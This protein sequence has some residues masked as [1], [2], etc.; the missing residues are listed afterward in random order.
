MPGILT[1]TLDRRPDILVRLEGLSKDLEPALRSSMAA[2]RSVGREEFEN[3]V[4]AGA[5]AQSCDCRIGGFFVPTIHRVDK[6][7]PGPMRRGNQIFSDR[8]HG[9]VA[10]FDIASLGFLEIV[11][12]P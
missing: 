8:R 7:F 4:S 5:P 9:P 3:L 2:W 10:F 12:G 1:A 6:C 11:D